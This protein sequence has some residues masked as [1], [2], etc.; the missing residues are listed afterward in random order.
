M[1]AK[2]FKMNVTPLMIIFYQ[3]FRDLSKEDPL[4]LKL[5]FKNIKL[6]GM[7]FNVIDLSIYGTHRERRW[8]RTLKI[9]PTVF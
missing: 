2:P 6:V 4:R 5:K 3:I 9:H 8:R 1:L 7:T